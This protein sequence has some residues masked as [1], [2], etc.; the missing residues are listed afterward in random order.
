GLD[1][2]ARDPARP[3]QGAR[4]PDR[5]RADVRQGRASSRFGDPGPLVPEKLAERSG[6]EDR[7]RLEGRRSRRRREPDG[8]LMAERIYQALF[9]R[10]ADLAWAPNGALVYRSRRVRTFEDLPA[11]PALCQ[12]ETDE[13][14]A[15]VTSQ[16]AVTTLG[17]TWLVYHQA[18]KDDDAVPAA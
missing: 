18:G 4:L 17:A 2:A 5:R 1:L 13:T 14:V 3:S 7:R 9:D 8:A 12:A 11:Q 10:P 6:G 16:Q 15:Q